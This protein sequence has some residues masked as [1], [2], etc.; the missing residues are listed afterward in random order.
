MIRHRILAVR[1][2][3]TQ[4]GTFFASLSQLF[5]SSLPVQCDTCGFSCVPGKN[6]CIFTG[7]FVGSA[8]AVNGFT[9]GKEERE[10]GK[11]PAGSCCASAKK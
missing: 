3:N 1:L 10:A 11:T 2:L 7:G 9:P 5:I 6:S 4:V 8:N